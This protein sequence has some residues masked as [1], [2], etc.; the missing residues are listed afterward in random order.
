MR[1]YKPAESQPCYYCEKI[2]AV[3]EQHDYPIRDGIYTF[4]EYVFR[5]AWHS[6]FTCDNCGEEYHFS[7]FY[8]CPTKEKLV[9]GDCTKPTMKL[10]AFWDRTYAYQFYCDDCEDYHYDILYAEFQGLHPW[11]LGNQKLQSN[12]DISE[13][14][15]P[16][17]VP[18]STREGGEI[19]LDDA[20][21]LP[22]RVKLLRKDL[23]YSPNF[24]VL[25][26]AVPEELV[27]LSQ[28]QKSWEENS[29]EWIE[30]T[31]T[32]DPYKSSD[33]NRL[34]IIDPALWKLIGE[35]KGLNVLDAGCGNGYFT[36]QL[37]SNGANAVGVDFSRGFIHHCKK[38]EREMKLGCKFH[39]ASIT[40]M[41]FLDSCSFD[42]IVS[43]IVLV[44]VLDY[45]GAFKEIARVLNDEGRFIWSNVHPVFGRAGSAIDP[46]IPRDSK[47]NESRYLKV[48]D[49]YF[50][51]GGHLSKWWSSP[52]WQFLR[53]FEE[54]SKALKEA[55]FVISEIVEPRPTPESIQQ[56]PRELAFDADR[57]THFVIFECLKYK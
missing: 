11:Q 55:G 39:E 15:E 33:P 4:E 28:T 32:L 43:N 45:K 54:Y 19:S 34:Y 9:C 10:V 50:D 1:F 7:W 31:E 46:K 20:L 49:R 3:E 2:N 18:N 47:R 27:K 29:Q 24:G 12:L 57:W 41:P 36:R 40:D 51:S 16:V 37:A 44:D 52:V 48:T 22:N 14:W 17:W 35:V 53:T 56:H 38:L 21:K 25:Q 42:I 8:W 30:L 5:C 23:K 6:R 13:P 26:Y